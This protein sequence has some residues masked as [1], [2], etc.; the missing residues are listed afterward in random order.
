MKRIRLGFIWLLAA[1]FLATGC[2]QAEITE[3]TQETGVNEALT[4]NIDDSVVVEEVSEVPEYDGQTCI[5]VNDNIP[6][7][8]E[9]EMVTE[10]FEEYAPLDEL[11]RCGTAYANVCTDIMPTEERGKI[12]QV[13][14]SG[15]HTVKYN[16][17]IDGNYLY[18]RC[19]LIGYQLSGENAN[20]ENLITGT[21]W[22]NVQ[23]MLPFENMV[24]DYVQET[25]NH[26]LYRVTP[27]FEEDN[28]VAS[29][30]QMEAKSVED[31]GIAIC[32][33][34]FI[35]NIQPGIEIDYE[36]GDSQVAED[37]EQEIAEA[38]AW[39]ASSEEVKQAAEAEETES[40]TDEKTAIYIAN[41]NTKKFHREN[42]SSV[43]DIAEK[44]RLEFE[45]ERDQ[46]IE[47]GYSPC[48]RCNP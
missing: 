45:G 46:L 38:E 19:H 21:R 17:L 20:E 6:E 41:K 13:R 16:D 2:E 42:C 37:Y 48:K 23:G 9:E 47:M 11:G 5:A 44:N 32:F 43:D 27:V 12:G 18:N 3:T 15:W 26:V 35:Y 28:L 25:D 1:A 34:V 8:T 33:N 39:E 36:T 24:A 30:V 10:A 14:P 22:L 4:V 40:D 31:N 29:G 7:F